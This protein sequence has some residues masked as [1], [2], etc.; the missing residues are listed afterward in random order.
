[1]DGG[2]TC[3]VYTISCWEVLG[4]DRDH[5][6]RQEQMLPSLLASLPITIIC[7]NFQ[8]H[9]QVT[10]TDGLPGILKH[11]RACPGEDDCTVNQSVG[12][13]V[14][15]N[16]GSRHLGHSTY[17]LSDSNTNGPQ[18]MYMRDGNQFT[19]PTTTSGLGSTT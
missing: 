19:Y 4:R 9:H 11:I 1:M 7:S 14:P 8:V 13:P 12:S 16:S 15:A 5:L 10:P 2:W 17:L 6:V 3:E 18:V